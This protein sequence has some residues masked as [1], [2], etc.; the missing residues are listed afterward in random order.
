MEE[1][2]GSPFF[3]NNDI[4]D[5]GFTAFSH[6]TPYGT[7]VPEGLPGTPFFTI[8]CTFLDN[9]SDDMYLELTYSDTFKI[10]E[11]MLKQA[12]AMFSWPRFPKYAFDSNVVTMIGD[13]ESVDELG[14]TVVEQV[15]LSKGCWTIQLTLEEV[16]ILSDLMMVKWLDTQIFTANNT[17]MKYSSADIKFTSQA[18]HIQKLTVLKENFQKSV[19]SKMHMYKRQKIDRYGNVTANYDGLATPKNVGRSEEWWKYQKRNMEL[20]WKKEL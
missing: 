5:P 6:Y 8:Y 9:I 13:K 11:R 4:I 3:M 12:I 19:K 20:T 2:L 15:A 16:D 18:N 1:N 14:N 10:L 7:K 17:Q